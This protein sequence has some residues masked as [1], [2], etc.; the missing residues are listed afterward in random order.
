M[1]QTFYNSIKLEISVEKIDDAMIVVSVLHLPISFHQSLLSSG[2]LKFQF[3]I[4]SLNQLCHPTNS[5]ISKL[6]RTLTYAQYLLYDNYGFY[7]LRVI[8]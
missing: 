3:F 5:L 6:N 7:I 1:V 4:F 2:Y 8:L